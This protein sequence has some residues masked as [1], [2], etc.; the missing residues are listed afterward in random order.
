MHTN[1]AAHRLRAL[2]AFAPTSPASFHNMS[3]ARQLKMSSLLPSMA[4]YVPHV[5][6]S[7]PVPRIFAHA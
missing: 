1:F 7:A 2:T 4:R 6:C 5:R 3:M